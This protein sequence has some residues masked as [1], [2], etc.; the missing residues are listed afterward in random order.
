MPAKTTTWEE[1]NFLVDDGSVAATSETGVR[2]DYYIMK[3]GK[4]L[5]VRL[6]S[7][8]NLGSDIA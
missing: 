5:W 6:R 2:Y 4:T 3:I 8:N 1:S 7:N